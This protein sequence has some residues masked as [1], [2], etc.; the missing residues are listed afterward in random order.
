MICD[1]CAK[2]GKKLAESLSQ[3]ERTFLITAT[4]LMMRGLMES[5]TTPSTDKVVASSVVTKLLL[6]FPAATA[7]GLLA[8]YRQGVGIEI[9]LGNCPHHKLVVVG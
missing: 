2:H 5:P 8:A 6:S 7:A 4:M 1:E 9:K 3:S